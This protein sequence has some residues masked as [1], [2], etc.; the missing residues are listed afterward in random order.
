VLLVGFPVELQS[1]TL[2]CISGA[3]GTIFLVVAITVI[4]AWQTILSL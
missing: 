2:L 1:A 3:V 4:G